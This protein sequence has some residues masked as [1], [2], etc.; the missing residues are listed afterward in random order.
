MKEVILKTANE[1]LEKRPTQKYK[2]G[3]KTWTEEIQKIIKD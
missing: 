2:R 1:V 3:L